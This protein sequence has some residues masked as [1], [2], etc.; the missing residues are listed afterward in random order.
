MRQPRG[1]RTAFKEEAC[2]ASHPAL[3]LEN[4]IDPGMFPGSILVGQKPV[5]SNCELRSRLPTQKTLP[6]T[7]VATLTPAA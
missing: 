1:Y 3:K 4:E 5:L 7:R 6:C 2:H